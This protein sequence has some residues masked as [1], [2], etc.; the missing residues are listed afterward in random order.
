MSLTYKVTAC[1]IRL[2]GLKNPPKTQ[3]THAS[4]SKS[5]GSAFFVALL[6]EYLLTLFWSIIKIQQ[7]DIIRHGLLF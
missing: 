4:F 1:V 3:K 2:L 6:D 5:A 7:S